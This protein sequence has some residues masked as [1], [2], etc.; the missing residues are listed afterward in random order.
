MRTAFILLAIATVC[1]AAAI[2]NSDNVETQDK[3]VQL[4]DDDVVLVSDDA[5]IVPVV[6]QKRFLK[7]I[8]LAKLGLLGIG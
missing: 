8:K 3:L 4:T 7:K 6:R 5:S 1:L 2:D